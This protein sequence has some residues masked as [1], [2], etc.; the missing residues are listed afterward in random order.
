MITGKVFQL[1]IGKPQARFVFRFQINQLESCLWKGARYRSS[2]RI[3]ASSGNGCLSS[4]RILA[5]HHSLYFTWLTVRDGKVPPKSTT[6]SSFSFSSS[7]QTGG[8]VSSFPLLRTSESDIDASGNRNGSIYCNHP[9]CNRVH[10]SRRVWHERHRLE[11]VRY[12]AAIRNNRCA[13][14]SSVNRA[15][16][17]EVQCL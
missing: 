1:E 10:S 13:V 5:C 7:S 6:T 14:R 9:H 16:L 2:I 3:I 11:K 15:K 12:F 17:L 8:A 4:V